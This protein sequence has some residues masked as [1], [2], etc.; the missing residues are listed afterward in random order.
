MLYS[1]F[2]YT[3]GIVAPCEFG[4]HKH[5]RSHIWTSHGRPPLLSWIISYAPIS[6]LTF[7][8]VSVS[9]DPFIPSR[10]WLLYDATH[11]RHYMNGLG[12]YVAVPPPWQVLSVR[13]NY[14]LRPGV[15]WPQKVWGHAAN[16]CAQTIL[17]DYISKTSGAHAVG[18]WVLCFPAKSSLP[19]R[20]MSNSGGRVAICHQ[21]HF[22]LLTVFNLVPRE[23]IS[24]WWCKGSYWLEYLCIGRTVMYCAISWVICAHF[25]FRQYFWAKCGNMGD[26]PSGIAV[27]WTKLLSSRGEVVNAQITGACKAGIPLPR[28]PCRGYAA[29][30]MLKRK[31]C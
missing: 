31:F 25:L 4:P 9:C 28:M 10:L 26:W 24:R 23:I 14:R 22:R 30:V 8:F 6:I 21:K 1:L 16:I 3:S 2:L 17:W 15:D 11:K 20:F 18:S 27:T 7:K 12:V 19:K 29:V 5:C 13:T